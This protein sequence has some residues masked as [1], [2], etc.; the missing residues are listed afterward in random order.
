MKYVAVGAL[1]G[2]GAYTLTALAMLTAMGRA[3][4]MI[5]SDDDEFDDDDLLTV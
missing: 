2:I 1:V 5:D 4:S 3:L